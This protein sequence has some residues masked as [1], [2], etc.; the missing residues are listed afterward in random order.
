[1]SR[2]H[3]QSKRVAEPVQVYLGAAD[4][5][6]LERLTT[7]LDATKSDVLRRGLESLE[8]QLLDP[9]AHPALRL[10]G[11]AREAEP[12]KGEAGQRPA[13][14]HDRHLADTEIA[15]WRRHPPGDRD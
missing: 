8:R 9:A 15:S 5:E 12:G 1:M 11:M 2:Y 14:G 10:I 3:E 7:Q 13:D 4:R 6:R